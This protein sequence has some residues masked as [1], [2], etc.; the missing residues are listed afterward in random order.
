M[1]GQVFNIIYIFANEFNG[2]N[3]SGNFEVLNFGFIGFR[4][5]NA[6]NVL[7]EIRCRGKSKFG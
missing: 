3:I 2:V 4:N 7:I 6:Y 1:K 5:A